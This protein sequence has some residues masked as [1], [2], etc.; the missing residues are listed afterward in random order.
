MIVQGCT[1]IIDADDV[2]AIVYKFIHRDLVYESM[3]L[4]RWLAACQYVESQSKYVVKYMN[5]LWKNA[6]THKCTRYQP[7]IATSDVATMAT[8]IAWELVPT[9]LIIALFWHVRNSLR[10]AVKCTVF[11]GVGGLSDRCS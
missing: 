6:L 2:T 9:A 5:E 8:L 3:C 4:P 7:P 10:I 11:G 1:A